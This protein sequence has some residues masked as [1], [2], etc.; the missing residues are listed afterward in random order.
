[1]HDVYDYRFDSAMSLRPIS[2]VSG[3]EKTKFGLV[4]RH[5]FDTLF[6]PLG[7]WSQR[8]D[9]GALD[10]VY[11]TLLLYAANSSLNFTTASRDKA[12]DTSCTFAAD[13]KRR[14]GS[15]SRRHR[16]S[17]IA[18]SQFV[19]GEYDEVEEEL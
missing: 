4:C 12:R 2:S 5:V 1:M 13:S 8:C 11:T 6:F 3:L 7:A 16:A 14:L 10:C 17:T 18:A 15:T 9:I 19:D